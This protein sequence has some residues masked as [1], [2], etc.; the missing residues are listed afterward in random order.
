MPPNPTSRRAVLGTLIFGFSL[1]MLLLFAAG[2]AAITNTRLIQSAA[3]DLAR[4]QSLTARL[5]DEIQREHSFVN[6]LLQHLRRPVR[7]SR[8]QLLG[9]LQEV[10]RRFESVVGEATELGTR[11]EWL[12]T[13]AAAK[14]FCREARRVLSSPNLESVELE[15]LWTR[16]EELLDQVVRLVES[17]STRVASVERQLQSQ[18]QSM[19]RQSMTLLG[20]SGL[21]AFAC[22]VLTIWLV[23]RSFNRLAEQESE[24]A[25]VSFHLMQSQEESAQRFSHELH[26]EMGQVLSAFKVNL[27]TMDAQNLDERRKDCLQLTDHALASVRELSQLLRPVILDDFGLEAALAWLADR[28][29]A[30]TGVNVNY[31]SSGAG[32]LAPETET[33]LFRIAQEALTNIARHSKASKVS[34]SYAQS[35]KQATLKIDDNGI[36]MAPDPARTL[37]FGLTGMRARARHIGGE[38]KLRSKPGQGFRVEVR[39]PTAEGRS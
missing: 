16:H 13:A 30:R 35:G 8:T 31:N 23:G 2:A 3:L 12:R 36:G 11:Q 24:L 38:L 22:A 10:E 37:G 34:V 15:S 25:R 26:D 18:S 21:A 7:N 33:H 32:R 5:I 1:V 28:F 4:E 19:H 20:L 6:T 39:V 27:V 14:S 29:S 17:S 9:E